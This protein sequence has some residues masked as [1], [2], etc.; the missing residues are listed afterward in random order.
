MLRKTSGEKKLSR[1]IR[2]KKSNRNFPFVAVPSTTHVLKISKMRFSENLNNIKK[3]QKT[4]RRKKLPILK[5]P[6]AR[7]RVTM[8]TLRWMFV[9]VFVY[10]T[11]GI[12][13]FLLLQQGSESIRDI[14]VYSIMG[15]VTF[16]MGYFGWR[17]AQILRE[18][19]ISK[20]PKDDF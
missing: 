7:L 4:P 16:F 13:V 1:N 14:V 3:H 19:V 11:V 20:K 10:L 6:F 17:V 9:L 2:R 8:N 12:I 5:T 18:A 15:F